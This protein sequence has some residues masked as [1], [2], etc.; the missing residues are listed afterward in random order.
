LH[1]RGSKVVGVFFL[2]FVLYT[3]HMYAFM[4]N[5]AQLSTISISFGERGRLSRRSVNKN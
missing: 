4:G 3:C 5:L 1:S 2:S